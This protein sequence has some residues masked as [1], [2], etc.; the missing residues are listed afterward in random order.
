MLDHVV[1]LFLVFCGNSILIS[2]M[3]ALIYAPTNGVEGSLLSTSSLTFIICRLFDD[4]HF[5][6]YEVKT[7]CGSDLNFSNN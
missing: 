3:A 5:N 2:T 4:S 1:I 6:R 7:P